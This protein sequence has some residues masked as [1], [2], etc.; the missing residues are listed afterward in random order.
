MGVNEKL[1]LSEPPSRTITAALK[2]AGLYLIFACLWILF[3]DGI[4]RRLF[5]GP[6]QL[7]SILA[8]KEIPF[9]IITLALFWVWSRR[10]IRNVSELALSVQEK[11]LNSCRCLSTIVELSPNVIFAKD[12]QGRYLIFNQKAA[13]VTGKHADAVL[14]QDDSFIFPA[15]E[16]EHILSHDRQVI[17]ENK[18]IVHE[19]TLTGADGAKRIFQATKGVLRDDSDNIVGIFGICYDITEQKHSEEELRKNEANFRS[20]F[21]ENSSPMLLIDHATGEII[22]ANVA[23]LAFYGY[24]E[25]QFL[26]LHI[27]DINPSSPQDIARALQR[28]ASGERRARHTIHLL[29]SG[30]MRDVELHATHINR[31]GRS[32]MLTIVHDITQRKKTERSLHESEARLRLAL[33]ASNQGWFDIDLK[34]GDITVSHEYL[35]IAGYA[36]DEFL[37]SM[38]ELLARAHPDDRNAVFSALLAGSK[39][40]EPFS[41][42]YRQRKKSGDYR[43]VRSIGRAVEWDAK[44]YASRLIGI[45]TDI[46]ERKELEEQIR[47]LAFFDPLTSLPNRR[48]LHDRLNRAMEASKRSGR[49][50]AVM[51][52][53]M[54]NFKPLNDTH[55]H[56]VGDLLLIEAA[57]RLASCVRAVDTVARFGGDEFV[58]MIC[59]LTADRNESIEQARAVAEKIRLALAR[60]YI[61]EAQDEYGSTRTIE[62]RCSA[63]IG[64][65][66]FIDHQTSFA[67]ILKE[68]DLAMYAAKEAGRNM[69]RFHEEF[70]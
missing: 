34:S 35:D 14:G 61:L 65:T 2:P 50:C 12:L 46:T 33:T 23:A 52:S 40:G 49:Y 32:F 38:E 27:E 20:L 7:Q 55:G 13:Q 44:G 11:A 15:D 58:I 60:P 66:L 67:D 62:H 43:W 17:A 5:A 47:Q 57:N 1:K 69:I 39:D 63:S 9:V 22:G 10:L 56:E 16:I 19:V 26:K 36:R 70:R 24:T 37:P 59:E 21:E 3:S 48:L 30:E 51:F 18:T 6:E 8:W 54:D 25:E 28:A 42:E 64:I 31:N 68:A 4:A 45:K 53:D 41:I 29:A